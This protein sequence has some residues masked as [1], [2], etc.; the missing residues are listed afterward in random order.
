[1]RWG[2]V[3]SPEAPVLDRTACDAALPSRA[4]NGETPDVQNVITPEILAGPAHA[5]I[6]VQ[7]IQAVDR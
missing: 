5:P 6:T 1:M 7:G 3:E 2:A 4:E